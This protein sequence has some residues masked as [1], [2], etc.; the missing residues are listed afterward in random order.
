MKVSDPAAAA[1]MP[2]ETGAP[3]AMTRAS[4]AACATRLAVTTSMVEQSIS[5][6]P[7]AQAG[8]IFA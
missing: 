8:R 4:T 3:T 6:V 2:S 7:A 1:A 5:T